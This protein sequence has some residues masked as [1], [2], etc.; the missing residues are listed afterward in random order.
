[1]DCSPSAVELS[2]GGTW[3]AIHSFRIAMRAL[4]ERGD[5][6]FSPRSSDVEKV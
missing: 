3:G 1:M 4:V 6:D 2:N 5:L